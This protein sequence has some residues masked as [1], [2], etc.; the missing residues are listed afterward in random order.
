MMTRLTSWSWKT[1]R[2][3]SRK[4]SPPS[5][6][7]YLPCDMLLYMSQF[8]QF[9]NY[10]NLIEAYWPDGG[11]DQLIRRRLWKLST[12]VYSTKFFNGKELQVEFNYDA[13][14]PKEDRILLNVETLLPI[15]GPIFSTADMDDQLWMN[16]S[17]VSDIVYTRYDMDRCSEYR[18]ANCDCC[19]RLHDTVDYPES[20]AEFSGFECLHGH[21]HH[22]CRHHVDWW[23]KRYLRTSIQLQQA[24]PAPPK[25]L[26]K[27]RNTFGNMLLRCLCIP[28]GVESTVIS[29]DSTISRAVVSEIGN[30]TAVSRD[31]VVAQHQSGMI[32]KPSA[33]ITFEMSSAPA[34][35]RLLH[36]F[37]WQALQTPVS[38]DTSCVM[39]NKCLLCAPVVFAPCKCR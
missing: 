7:P 34:N 1:S 35:R 37:T 10:R 30:E 9:E 15:T 32:S 16:P 38:R 4:P 11:E 20:F 29:S 3:A 25:P 5:D 14:R 28:A 26:P 18:Y 6:S 21:F 24:E 23:L 39:T 2:E 22:Y 17:K 33:G 13:K 27:R 12:R 8:L 31:A 36:T 19:E